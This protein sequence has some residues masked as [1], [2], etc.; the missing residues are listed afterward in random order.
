MSIEDIS[1]EHFSALTHTEIKAST[2]EC[3]RHA[4]FH[5]FF[6]DDSKQD[7]ETTTAHIKRLIEL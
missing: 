3:P 7:A 1:L 5:Y 6:S 2:K 4:V